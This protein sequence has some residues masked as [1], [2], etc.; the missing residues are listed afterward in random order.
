MPCHVL[1]SLLF[2]VFHFK[3]MTELFCGLCSGLS[4]ELFCFS[5]ESSQLKGILQ[6]LSDLM[7][8]R[9]FFLLQGKQFNQEKLFSRELSWSL[10]E[11]QVRLWWENLI[12]HSS[13]ET[14]DCGDI[15]KTCIFGNC[16]RYHFVLTC[17]CHCGQP[18]LSMDLNGDSQSRRT[19]SLG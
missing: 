6:C 1:K 12:V 15:P 17:W 5:Q 14:P 3:E 11:R 16:E 8:K 9:I 10:W 7:G 18:T 13:S 19:K 2:G 4:G